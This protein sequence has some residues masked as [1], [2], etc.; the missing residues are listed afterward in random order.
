M[1]LAL[2]TL[3]LAAAAT[4]V[5]AAPLRYALT[6]AGVPFGTLT[7]DAEEAGGRYR[8]ALAFEATGLAGF[9][10]YGLEGSAI[11]RAGAD[12]AL[13]PD[14]FTARSH[15]PRAIR[16][17]RIDWKDGAP[18]FVA[19]DPPRADA[20]DPAAAAGAVDPA[21]ALSAL[22]LPHAAGGACGERVEVFDGSRLVR[23]QL[24]AATP[25]EGEIVCGG[26][27]TRLGGEPLT[28][29]EPAECP[30]QL[31]YGIE[32][33]GRAVLQEIRIPTRFGPASIARVA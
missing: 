22:A 2:A 17:T 18:A 23:L 16:H 3:L 4:P 24:D 8:S 15:S 19:V 14:L 31:R 32:P 28:P 29:I 30:F 1:R 20:V 6:L 9:L 33:D 25:R 7:I 26:L 27:Y 13:A 11:G 10:D 12:H 21:T 5:A